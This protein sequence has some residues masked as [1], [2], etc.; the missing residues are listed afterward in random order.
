MEVCREQ[1]NAAIKNSETELIFSSSLKTVAQFAA[2]LSEPFLKIEY[3]LFFYQVTTK[4]LIF[5]SRSFQKS[6]QKANI[7]YTF[8]WHPYPSMNFLAQVLKK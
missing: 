6:F 1:V 8:L 3:Y 4:L 2:F 5:P 7:H